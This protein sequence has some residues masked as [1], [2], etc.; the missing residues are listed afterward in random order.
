MTTLFRNRSAV[1]VF[2]FPVLAVYTVF[3]TYPIVQT[4]IM[5][6]F[7]WDGISAGVFTFLDNYRDL[8]TDEL[9]NTSL[10]NG[11]IYALVMF[12]FSVAPALIVA[13]VLS[14]PAIQEK[15]L[16][17]TIFFIPVV[18]SVTVVCQLWSSILHPGNGLINKLLLAMGSTLQ[19]NWFDK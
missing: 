19:Q 9:L 7:S 14:N 11:F 3:L 16:L 6:T 12:L 17:R 10:L 13:F 4:F 1:F 18:L 15:K 2:S 5:S 8:F